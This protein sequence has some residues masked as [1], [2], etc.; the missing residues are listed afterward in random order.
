MDARR[1]V[2]P[3]RHP[4]SAKAVHQPRFPAA[5][6]A[7]HQQ[8]S[9]PVV[10]ARV[11]LRI[12]SPVPAPAF[13][14][15]YVTVRLICHVLIRSAFGGNLT[16]GPLSRRSPALGGSRRTSRHRDGASGEEPNS[17]SALLQLHRV[18]PG[19]SQIPLCQPWLT[20]LQASSCS[21][22]RISLEKTSWALNIHNRYK[23]LALAGKRQARHSSS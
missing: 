17:T 7:H 14:S 8:P 11:R 12:T 6:A 15:F 5:R 20:Y 21:A 3:V 18:P 23:N 10:R 22:I 9:L 4:A 1:L 2:Q 16:E 13:C 19:Q